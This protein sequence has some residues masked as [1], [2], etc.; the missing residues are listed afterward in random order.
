MQKI[1]KIMIICLFISSFLFGATQHEIDELNRMIKIINAS[2]QLYEQIIVLATYNDGSEAV[3]N[4]YIEKISYYNSNIKPLGNGVNY[5]NSL[6]KSNDSKL[7]QSSVQKVVSGYNGLVE[8][9]NAL[10][11][12]GK[13]NSSKASYNSTTSSSNIIKANTQTTDNQNKTN[14]KPN[15]IQSTQD[16]N[17]Y[18]Q[19]VKNIV[20][21]NFCRINGIKNWSNIQRKER[22]DLGSEGAE[23]IYYYSQDGIEK[24]V[25]SIMG[26][27]GN[28][29]TEFYFLN[30]TISFIYDIDSSYNMPIYMDEYDSKK[31]KKIERRYYF[32]E[33]EYFRYLTSETKNPSN[34]EKEQKGRE[35]IDFYKKVL[36]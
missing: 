28:S 12:L 4:R 26:E 9:N 33:K 1:K 7:I 19:Y 32:K 8:V 6:A 36:N 10:V 25:A 23:I 22:G 21:P 13:R 20:R 11:E 34:S 15:Y 27:S 16:N 14:I 35:I 17:T 30:N 29:V 31:T 5:G 3:L 18:E 24:I 2:H